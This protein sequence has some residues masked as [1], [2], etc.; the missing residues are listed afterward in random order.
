M[1]AAPSKSHVSRK[2][3]WKPDDSVDAN[4]MRK[5]WKTASEKN[6]DAA[7]AE[8]Y[9]ELSHPVRWGGTHHTK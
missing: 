8:L 1:Y 9:K 2:G 4:N 6:T 5:S 7:L 3:A